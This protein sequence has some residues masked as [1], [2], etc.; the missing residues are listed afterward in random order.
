MM[1][2]KEIIVTEANRDILLL[3]D[4]EQDKAVIL[5]LEVLS[6]HGKYELSDETKRWAAYDA[7]CAEQHKKT[8]NFLKENGLEVKE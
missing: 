6:K 2:A 4:I 1:E 3:T 5:H 8:C 7:I